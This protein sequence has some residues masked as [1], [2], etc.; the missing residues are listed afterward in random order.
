MSER[1]CKTCS[2]WEPRSRR[3]AVKV[4]YV[5][6]GSCHRRA[7]VAFQA[8]EWEVVDRSPRVHSDWPQ[9]FSDDWCG[10]HCDR[11]TA[12]AEGGEG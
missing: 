6:A 1:I 7:P 5:D 9:T 2:W 8:P 3:D 4:L 11:W 12:R 10:E